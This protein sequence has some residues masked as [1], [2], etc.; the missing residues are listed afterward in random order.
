M[1]CLHLGRFFF[2]VLVC[3]QDRNNS[4]GVDAEKS[5][6]N[7]EEDYRKQGRWGDRDKATYIVGF[8]ISMGSASSDSTNHG[9]KIC[10]KNA[11]KF[12]KAKLEFARHM[13][14]LTENVHCIYSYIHSTDI[15]LGIITNLEMI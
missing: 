2:V 11:R 3:V 10:K 8:S 12:Q 14:L 9:S 7:D 15:I 5:N 1:G 4:V 13:Q 6:S